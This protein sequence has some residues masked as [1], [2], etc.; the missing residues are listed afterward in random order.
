MHLYKADTFCRSRTFL[1]GFTVL[2][3][4][5]KWTTDSYLFSLE[6]KNLNKTDNFEKSLLEFSIAMTD[7]KY[8]DIHESKSH[9]HMTMFE[10]KMQLKCVNR[11]CNRCKKEIFVKMKFLCNTVFKTDTSIRRTLFWATKVSLYERVVL[12]NMVVIPILGGGGAGGTSTH[13]KRGCA[14][15]TRKVVLKNLGT[16]LKLRPKNP[17]TQNTRLSF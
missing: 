4:S 12:C 2:K 7:Q 3:L 10:L 15:L 16:Y 9:S 11:S 8:S 13:N 5:I 6:R 17:R 1:V 14:I